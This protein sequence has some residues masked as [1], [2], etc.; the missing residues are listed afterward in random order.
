MGAL[1]G[2]ERLEGL[3]V[4]EALQDSR[5]TDWKD[6]STAGLDRLLGPEDWKDYMMGRSGGLEGPGGLEI[7][8]IADPKAAF[9]KAV[10]PF[11]CSAAVAVVSSGIPWGRGMAKLVWPNWYGGHM[12]N[13]FGGLVAH[14]CEY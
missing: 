13:H 4:P 9:Q 7:P 5:T 11:R 12:A 1:D 8:A 2:P 14:Q 6:W 3:E 10:P